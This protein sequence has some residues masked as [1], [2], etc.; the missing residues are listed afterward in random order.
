MI[1]ESS[2]TIYYSQL[3]FGKGGAMLFAA[4]PY[5]TLLQPK[6]IS[7]VSRAFS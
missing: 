3:K 1:F 2:P 6:F 4:S 5:S 7:A